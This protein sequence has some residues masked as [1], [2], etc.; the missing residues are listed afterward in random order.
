MTTT[1]SA[2][3]AIIGG[4]PAGLTAAA[5]LASRTRARVVVLEREQEA[6][7]IPRHSDHLGYGIRDKRRFTTGPRYARRLVDE[8]LAAGADLR[9]ETMVT[10]WDGTDMLVTSPEG[11]ARVEATAIVLATGARERPRP[12]R[13]IPGS[14]PAGVLTTG[15]LQN[16]VHLHHRT[17]GSRAVVVG[18]ELVSWSA[19]MTLKEAGCRTEALVTSHAA[20]ESYAVFN[21]GGRVMFRPRLVTGHRV[22]QVLGRRRVEG[23]EVEDIA[24]GRREVL[25]CDTV[26]FTGDWIP[27]HELARSAG[28]AL[29]RGTRGPL[30]DPLGRT[31]RE[32]VFA[33][34]N[35]VHPVDTADVAAL[36]GQHVARS[37]ARFLDGEPMPHV[38]PLRVVG[39]APFAWVTPGLFH[40]RLPAPARSR[41]ETWVT[42]FVRVP[43]VTVRQ[44][45]RVL[46]RRALPWPASPGRVFRVPWNVLDG[47]DP[48]GGPIHLSL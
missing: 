45:G 20:P 44:D 2:D 5:D 13:M 34:G 25:P 4:G 17:V 40:P 12:A 16:T 9:T 23:V 6:G 21:L 3:V 28:I 18:G 8:A 47:A 35:L 41:L 29:D 11:R 7:G 37:V 46:T 48:N 26:V 32:G 36:G 24:T 33:A 10:S 39:D 15:E 19:V 30:V 22:V 38:A 14:R 31:G 1:I 43:R 42:E 27:D